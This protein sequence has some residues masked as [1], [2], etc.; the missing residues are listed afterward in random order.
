MTEKQKDNGAGEEKV[1]QE[2][3][4]GGILKGLSGLIDSLGDLA[5]TGRKLRESGEFEDSKGNIKGIY[6]FSVKVGLGDDEPQVEPFGNIRKEE[7]SGRTVVQEVREPVIDIFEE[8]DHILILAEMPGISVD[9]VQ[10]ELEEDILTLKAKQGDRRFQKEIQ[11]PGHF[12][13]EKMLLACNNGVVEI[14]CHR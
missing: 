2:R 11:L 6:G 3:G 14:K 5:E 8:K 4:V 13:K 12:D 10:L 9:N 7:K 1:H